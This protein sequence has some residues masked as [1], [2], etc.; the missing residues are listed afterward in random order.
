MTKVFI[1]NGKRTPI[2]SFMGSLS[3]LSAVD[4]GAHAIKA[5]MQDSRRGIA[6]I[7]EVIMGMVLTAATGQNPGRQMAVKAGLDLRVPSWTINKVCA[8]GLKAVA[9]AATA[10][11]AGQAE[12]VIAGGTESM[13]NAPHCAKL[14]GGLRFGDAQ[15]L[16]TI[17]H[18][19]LTDVY[20]K[21]SMGSCAEKTAAD[22]QLTREMQDAYCVR[23]Y[24]KALRA[25]ADGHFD[26]EI[27]PLELP[28]GGAIAADDEPKRFDR[29]KI[30]TLKPAF[31]A[32]HE[33]RQGTITAASASKLNDGAC[34]LLLLSEG[35]V[36]RAGL[37]PWAEVI[38]HADAE[39]DSVD[40]NICPALA[41]RQLLRKAGLRV[42][43]VDYWEL[44]EAFAVTGLA[45]IQLLGLDADRVNVFGGAVALGHPIGMSGARI[46]LTLVNVLRV[47]GGSFGVACICNG[48]G[49]A[50]AI[51]IKSCFNAKKL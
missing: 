11:R 40:F 44:S 14:R 2:G 15:L 12:A 6:D 50:S 25:V 13:S 32:F 34:A 10:I 31:P 45:N 41:I 1:V 35:E 16:D 9:L 17:T 47:R 28:R 22:L 19:G 18:D 46:V 48:G 33:G 8:S 24:E 26:W 49:G 5:V 23:S 42:E 37:S 3:A 4:L 39:T 36:A 20:S 27:A 38:A 7:G 43:E 30:P 51:L 29:A 21:V